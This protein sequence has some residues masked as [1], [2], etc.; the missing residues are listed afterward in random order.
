M[1]SGSF[2]QYPVSSAA[3]FGLYCEWSGVQSVSGNYTDITVNVYLSYW[4]IDVGSKT[5]TVTAGGAA[6]T[7]TSPRIYHYNNAWT[8]KLLGSATVRVSHDGDGSKRNCTI[9]ATFPFGGTMNGVSVSSITASV[10]VDLDAI[11]RT[12]VP[13][14]SSEAVYFGES[15]TISTNRKADTFTHVL[16][17]S[18]GS[19]SGTISD[20]VEETYN[21]I[22]DPVLI[23]QIPSS[24]SGVATIGCTTYNGGT[25]IGTNYVTVTL[26]VPDS[27][28]TRPV[29]ALST[30]SP[31]N[32]LEDPFGS[33]Y[34][35]GITKVRAGYTAS[36]PHSTLSKVE[37]SIIAEDGSLIGTVTGGA[38]EAESG[39]LPTSGNITVRVRA[40]NARGQ[41]SEDSVGIAVLAYSPPSVSVSVCDRCDEG[42]TLKRSGLKLKI[43][44]KRVFSSL[45][46]E[47]TCELRYRMKKYDGT[48]FSA[49]APWQTL[50][51]AAESVSDIFSGIVADVEKKSAYTVEI[52]V[53]DTVG[54]QSSSIKYVKTCLINLH[55]G[56]GGDRAA[57]GMWCQQEGLEIAFE[58]QFDLGLRL[59]EEEI[60]IGGDKDTYYPVWIK[61][62]NSISNAQPVFLSIGKQLSTLSPAWAGNHIDTA[63]SSLS[64]GWLLWAK[65]WDG[66]GNYC[67]TLYKTEDYAK[68]VS[69]I[70]LQMSAVEG[71]VIYLR[72]GG[73][74]YRICCSCPYDCNVYLEETSLS[75]R[76]DHPCIVSPTGE[77]GNGGVL[78]KN[79]G[80][81]LI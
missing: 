46:G 16:T 66:N 31:V 18:F 20:Y 11:P 41:S 32:G 26:K 48:G 7:F 12:S 56:A 3:R 74:S 59:R 63:S 54:K 13:T 58:T 67:N 80:A 60:V 37:L 17:Y 10:T 53:V 24:W 68:L 8:Q 64:I 40:V 71:Y 72:G 25:L 23:D 77:I 27:K 45:D 62:W 69:K 1:L 28:D 19:V 61:P 15:V 5:C 70:E 29:I 73:A 33:I 50:I 42:G 34:I 9:S 4:N 51:S 78:F 75:G 30:V 38:S 57:F 49:S 55:L 14:V 76:D 43:E 44:A 39:N 2:Y 79:A 35:Q 36:A 81:G 52:G 6:K 47:N 21:W 65:G 22:P